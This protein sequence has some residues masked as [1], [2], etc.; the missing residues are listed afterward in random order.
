MKLDMIKKTGLMM[1]ALATVVASAYAGNPDRR[2]QAGATDLLIVPWAR[3]GGWTGVNTSLVRGIEA[4]RLNVAGLAFTKGTE[5]NFS[6]TTW[7]SGSDIFINAFGLAQRINESSAIGFSVMS[8]DLGTIDITTTENPDG[9]LGTYRPAFSN[10]GISYAKSFSDRIYGGATLRIISQSISDV[11]AQGV[12]FDAGIQYVTGPND[13]LK[14][15]ISLRNVGTPMRFGGDGLSARGVMQGS[16]VALTLSQRSQQFELPSLM[17]IGIS[18]DFYPMVDDAYRLTVAGNFTS[19][20]FTNDQ[21]GIGAEF[22]WRN[23]FAFRTGYQFES[24]LFDDI[25]VRQNVYT[26]LNFGFSVDAPF[27]K[28]Q[29]GLDYAY[30]GTNPFGG[31]HMIGIRYTL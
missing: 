16:N 28:S 25:F 5:L 3:S 13:A 8:L 23:I 17:N 24:A 20:S 18:Y 2:G 1:V 14:F 30:R 19:N 21:Y 4:E 27:N 26:G 11:S 7:L 9:G 12:A 10:I 31:T 6:R 22:S 29:F 15:G